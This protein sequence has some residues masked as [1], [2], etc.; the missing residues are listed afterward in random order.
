MPN[1][2]TTADESQ[3]SRSG[4]CV[5]IP[6]RNEAVLIARCVSSVIAAGISPADIFVVD[7]ASTDR[8]IDVLRQLAA[9]NVL[10]HATNRGKAMSVRHAIEHYGLD[11]RYAFL[12]LLDADSHVATDYFATI[13]ETFDADPDAVL[14]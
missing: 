12:A 1:P 6:A 13:V 10:S 5:V 9:V 14:V 3:R 7:D 11:Q 2:V 8:T 4:L